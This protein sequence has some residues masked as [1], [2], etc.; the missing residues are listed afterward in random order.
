MVTVQALV[1][2]HAPD[3]PAKLEPVAGVGVRLTVV[4]SLKLL[5]Q[6]K[7]QSIPLGLLEIV[8][9]PDPF[10]FMVRL[11]IG[12]VVNSAVTVLAAFMVTA[13]VLEPLH[14]PPQPTKRQPL[15]GI[16]VKLRLESCS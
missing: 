2:V 1:P 10:L 12:M 15:S 16:A 4:P 14:A 7:P 9:E 11:K 6:I 5:E 8:P 13:Q 3:Q